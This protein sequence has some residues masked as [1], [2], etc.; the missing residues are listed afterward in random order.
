MSVTTKNGDK[1]KTGLLGGGIVF[2][3]DARI[4]LLGTLDEVVSFL[5]LAKSVCR[6]R[7]LN[8]S[9]ERV[10]KDLFLL[11]AEV[12]V[13]DRRPGAPGIRINAGHVAALDR[14]MSV[15][16]PKI[17]GRSSCFAVPGQG[18]VSSHLDVARTLVR[19]AE[20]RAVALSRRKKSVNAHLLVYLNRLSD[21]LYVWAR[22]SECR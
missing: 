16:E 14:L 12:A 13:Y 10:Q 8:A 4:E 11:A 5:G 22:V 17:S 20:R 1:G 6:R 3:N 15:W 7:T 18:V 9:I 21:L 2:K 19:R